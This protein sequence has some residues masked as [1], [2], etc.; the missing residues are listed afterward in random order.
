MTKKFFGVLL[1]SAL[2]TG[3]ATISTPSWN[4]TEVNDSPQ[5]SPMSDAHLKIW[6]APNKTTE[7]DVV[8]RLGD[9][10]H[11]TTDLVEVKPTKDYSKY[12]YHVLTYFG[13]VNMLANGQIVF[14]DLEIV[15]NKEKL[16]TFA[17]ISDC[18]YSP[19]PP[20]LLEQ[21]MAMFN[22]DTESCTPTDTTRTIGTPPNNK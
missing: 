9:K 1:L 14:R 3:C 5:N 8:A 21:N 22:R 16:A 4:Q 19:T 6:F 18:Y 15:I 11:T 2:F 10:D 7:A 13:P 17:A 20:S 12:N